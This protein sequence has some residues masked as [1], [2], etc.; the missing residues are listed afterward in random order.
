MPTTPFDLIHNIGLTENEGRVYLATLELGQSTILEISRKSG[1]NR[2]SIYNFLEN[3]KDRGLIIQTRK[4]SREYFSAIHPRQFL[5]MEKIK[6]KQFELLLPELTTLANRKHGRPRV[7]FFEGLDGVRS[8][9]AHE[10]EA[11]KEILSWSD[12][13]ACDKLLGKDFFEDYF[14]PSRMRRGIYYRGIVVDSPTSRRNVLN[15]N[16][17][18]RE[19]KMLPM[20]GEILTEIDIFNDTVAL[21]SF[22]SQPPVAVLIEDQALAATM[23]LI[24]TA[25]WITLP[26]S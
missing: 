18:F 7:Q 9:Y 20:K 1:V 3:M 12:F 10:L 19:T 11:K 4:K 23:R 24:W 14:V 5:E 16:R 15:N 25:E 21:M 26:S 2:T 13:D 22:R 8:A 17:R 6:I